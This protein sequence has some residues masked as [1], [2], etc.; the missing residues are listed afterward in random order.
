AT[1]RGAE[2]RGSGR[3]PEAP[4]V[5][6][7]AAALRHAIYRILRSRIRSEALPDKELRVLNRM[8]AAAATRAC[9][10]QK[11]SGFGWCA[12]TRRAT[13]TDMLAPIAW[14]AADLP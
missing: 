12:G 2:L 10:A 9:L 8:L 3:T 11:G 5:H 14:S 13:T 1:P 4:P 7:A 6:R